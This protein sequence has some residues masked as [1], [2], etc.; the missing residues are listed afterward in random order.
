MQFK[1][2]QMAWAKVYGNISQVNFDRSL[3]YFMNAIMHDFRKLR[4]D[5]IEQL[6]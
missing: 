1:Q 5:E 2:V 3:K 6:A 4:E